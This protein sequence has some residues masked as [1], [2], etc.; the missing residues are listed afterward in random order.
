MR[1]HKIANVNKAL[2]FIESKGVRL[3]SI[4]AEGR[5]RHAYNQSLTY[6]MYLAPAL[7]C[8]LSCFPRVS[9]IVDGN[10]KMTLGMI[11]TIILRFAIQ[12]ISVEGKAAGDRNSLGLPAH[13]QYTVCVS[14]HV[15]PQF[16]FLI[17]RLY[18][19]G[20]ADISMFDR[21]ISIYV[22]Y[23]PSRLCTR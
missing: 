22:N 23:S 1:V 2:E 21:V 4:G 12:D 11:W 17:L 9:E 10:L 16:Y 19:N 5:Y 6:P 8:L 13:T 14:R 18:H 7:V 20:A 3:V 15:W